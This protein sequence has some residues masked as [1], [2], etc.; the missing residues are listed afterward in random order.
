MK[1]SSAFS[2]GYASASPITGPTP[3]ASAPSSGPCRPGPAPI[4]PTAE[5]LA[6]ATRS[7]VAFSWAA[8]PDVTW[9]RAGTSAW[10]SFS[11][12]SICAHEFAVASASR[13]R[14][15]YVSQT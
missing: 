9:T 6:V 11:A 1:A 10:R 2:S 15:L 4:A 3:S 7:N 8:Y 5:T 13:T 14:R 12:T